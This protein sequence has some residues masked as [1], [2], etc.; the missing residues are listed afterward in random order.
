MMMMMTQPKQHLYHTIIRFTGYLFIFIFISSLALVWLD[1]D[2]DLDIND[3]NHE[4]QHHHP[5]PNPRNFSFLRTTSE[6]EYESMDTSRR[7]VNTTTTAFPDRHLVLDLMQLSADIFAM[8]DGNG[9]DSPADAITNPKYQLELFIKANFS[10]HAMIV[11]PQQQVGGFD[12]DGIDGGDEISS[13]SST[14]RKTCIIVYRGSDDI[15]D[16]LVDLNIELEKSEF[17]NA[18]DDVMVHR[19]FQNALFGQNITGMVEDKVLELCGGGGE[20]SNGAGEAETEAEAEII[21]TGHSLGGA[22]AHIT[23][24]FLADKYPKM[25]ITVINFGSPRLG[26]APFKS[27]TEEKLTNLSVWRFVYRADIVPRIVPREMGYK[28]AGHLFMMYKKLS[29]VYYHQTG[30]QYIY[31]GAPWN[32]Y[33]TYI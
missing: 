32:W 9:N 30:L 14:T 23:G 10:T 18:P 1:L 24:T 5:R 29:K 8:D 28:H 21:V 2:L 26:N 7:S 17:I 31:M 22:N 33:C 27:W 25:K 19:G 3:D 12:V 15:N 13:S 6:Y 11:T 4:Q 16:W 20:S